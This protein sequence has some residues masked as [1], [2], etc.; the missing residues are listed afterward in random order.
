MALAVLKNP[1]KLRLAVSYVLCAAFSFLL[2][3]GG[4]PIHKHAAFM[5]KELLNL[6]I[7]LIKLVLEL[8]GC[9]FK[10]LFIGTDYGEFKAAQILGNILWIKLI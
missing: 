8:S 2:S 7:I 6:L 10:G 1:Q 3:Y 9:G 4:A 5:V